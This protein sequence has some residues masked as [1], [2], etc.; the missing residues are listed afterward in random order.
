M[1]RLAVGEQ[2][3]ATRDREDFLRS[4]PPDDEGSAESD[5]EFDRSVQQIDQTDADILLTVMGRKPVNG[6][7]LGPSTPAAQEEHPQ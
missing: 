3:D 4:F 6:R 1:R 5:A 2:A 7:E